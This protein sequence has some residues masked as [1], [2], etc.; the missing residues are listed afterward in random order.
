MGLIALKKEIFDLI[1][2][3]LQYLG[4][5]LIAALIIFKIAFFKE[6]M[7]VLLRNVLSMFWLFVLP[8]YFMM[9]YWKE[10]LGFTERFIIGTGLAAAVIGVISY[11]LGLVGLDIKFHAVAL[12]LILIAASLTV[13][14]RTRE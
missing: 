13:N 2:K 12:P 11:Y 4:I 14:L 7:I 10:K 1:K 5:L 8:G 9:L 6:N 3:E